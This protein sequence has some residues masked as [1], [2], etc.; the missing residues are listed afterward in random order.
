MNPSQ[1]DYYEVLGV[2]RD[3]DQ[4]AIKEAFRQLALRYHPDRNKEPGAE[5]KFK[6]IAEAYA[7]LS[8]PRKR[9]DYDA[10]GFAGVAGFSPE[11]LFGG[12]DLGD[13]FG[14]EGFEF[15]FGGDLFE[16][17]F[18]GRRRK[19]RGQ[20]ESIWVEVAIPLDRVSTG[21]EEVVTYSRPQACKL[22]GGSGAKAGSAPKQCASCGGRGQQVRGEKKGNITFQQITTCPAC[23]GRG[24]IIESLCPTCNGTGQT[25]EKEEIKVKIPPGVEE[26]TELRIPGHGL[27]AP[28]ASAPS[29]D[30]FVVV[31][32]LPDARFERRG[33]DLW[34]G[35]TLQVAEAALGTTL[36]IPSL[37]GSV[38]VSVPAGTQ[39]GSVLRL[40]GKGLPRHGQGRKG[41]LFLALSV[42]IPER[43][44]AQ[45]RK[46]FE[47]LRSQ[48]KAP[49]DRGEHSSSKERSKKKR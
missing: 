4:K 37:D 36:T 21:G 30:L 49:L 41:D 32:T 42:H 16:R 10:R 12:I 33:A 3:A 39:P 14:R 24:T 43:L 23:D 20:G 27:P 1:R 40:R 17:F 46:L 38:A 13:L 25:L 29:G 5:A 6:E 22:C 28:R 18:G 15:G 26:G 19:E 2:P 7:I 31:R 11:E 8:D 34:H 47:E 48:S 45:E 44:S 35:E 9:A